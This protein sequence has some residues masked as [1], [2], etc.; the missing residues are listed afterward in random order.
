MKVYTHSRYKY[1]RV[2][3]ISKRELKRFEFGLCK[4]PTETLKEY[5]DRQSDK[6]ELII[7]A[8]FFAM[9]N[10]NTCFNYISDGK[11]VNE[12][13]LYKWGIGVVGD[14][15]VEYGEMYS[16]KWTG[17]ISGYP[18]LLDNGEKIKIDYAK[19]LNYKARRTMLGYNDTTIYIVC[20]E[21]P[22][23]NF[24][25]MQNL[26]LELGCKYAI[27]LDGG[28]STKML[29]NGLSVTKDATNRPVDNVIA[30]YL[31]EEPTKKELY[32]VQLGAYSVKKNAQ[33]QLEFIRSLGEPYVS[34]YI[35][36]I[37]GLYKIQ[38]GAFSV[39]SNA[40]RMVEDLKNKGVSS[41]IVK[42]TL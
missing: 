21:N 28:G 34:A 22:G 24:K 18:N 23:M 41:F 19:E 6:P 37:N 1:V 12:V 30:V 31:K 33:K 42:V 8:G 14:V 17:W 35:T 20:V 40:E 10:G 13:P 39:K 7:N 36:Y 4:Q 27:N 9:N 15:D 26:M 25:Q 5:Y 2:A 32:K 29:H 3:E 11:I 38:V 16:D